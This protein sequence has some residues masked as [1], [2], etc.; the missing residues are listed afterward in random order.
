MSQISVDLSTVAKIN[1]DHH[2]TTIING[3]DHPI[4]SNTN[5]VRAVHALQR[6]HTVWSWLFLKLINRSLNTAPYRLIELCQSP[7]CITS[8]LNGIAH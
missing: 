1:D 3:I 5:P 8:N 7:E 6:N 4:I 2:K